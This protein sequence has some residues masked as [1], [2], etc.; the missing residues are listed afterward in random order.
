MELGSEQLNAL[1]EISI[2][3]MDHAAV[4]LSQLMK[5]DISLKV[6]RILTMDVARLPETLGGREQMVVGVCLKILGDARGNIVMIF[7]VYL[8]CTTVWR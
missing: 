8:L 7:T 4:A 5:R 3:G 6:P 1:R 2:V